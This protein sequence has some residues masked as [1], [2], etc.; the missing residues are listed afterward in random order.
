MNN[1][2]IL[3]V[4]SVHINNITGIRGFDEL[5]AIRDTF[6]YMAADQVRYLLIAYFMAINS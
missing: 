3:Y 5:T 1:Y 2:L 4:M 6:N